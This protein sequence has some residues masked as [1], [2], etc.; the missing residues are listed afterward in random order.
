[1]GNSTISMA[2]FNSYVKLPEGNYHEIPQNDIFR[3]VDIWWDLVEMFVNWI[4]VISCDI[5]WHMVIQNA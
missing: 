1:M 3:D 2:T 5:S 4:N